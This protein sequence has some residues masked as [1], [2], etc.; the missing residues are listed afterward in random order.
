MK[1]SLLAAGMAVVF[2]LSG[3]GQRRGPRG[4]MGMGTAPGAEQYPRRLPALCAAR[5][6]P[7]IVDPPF[8]FGAPRL[9]TAAL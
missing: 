7:E 3:F 2:V 9:T 5:P 6:E 4:G 1:R 8:D